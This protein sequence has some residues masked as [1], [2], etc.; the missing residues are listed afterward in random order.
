MSEIAQ[1]GPLSGHKAL[2]TGAAGGIGLA[3]AR[4]LAQT[5]AGLYLSGRN[6]DALEKAAAGL[7]EDFAVEVETQTANPANPVDAEALAIA[8][9]DAKVFVSCSGNLPQ[10]NINAVDESQWKRSWEAAVFAPVNL[11]REMWTYMFETS[12]SLMIVVID[13]TM[14]P[15]PDDV[16]ASSAGGALMSLVEALGKA[17]GEGAPRVLGLVTG[18]NAVAGDVAAAISR[19]ACEPERWPSGT[20]L[21]P[22]AINADT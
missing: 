13:A 18:R 14:A 20:L 17:N 5:G 6:M 8:C 19:M 16:C 21:S 3:A 12:D 4:A 15:N 2:V 7:R 11:I 10:G 1:G 9:D 22:Q